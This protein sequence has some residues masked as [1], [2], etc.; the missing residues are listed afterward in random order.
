[1][2]LQPTTYNLQ[3][4]RGFTLVET[5]VAI[6][7]MMVAIV[8]PMSIASQALSTARYAKE[9]VTAF[10]L[11]QEGIELVRDIRGNNVISGAAVWNEGTLGLSSPGSENYCYSTNGC[12]IEAKDLAV[13]NCSGI[14]PV[15]NIDL[16]QLDPDFGIYTYSLIGTNPSQ[17]AR[18]IRI[19]KL[20]STE[21]SVSSTVSWASGAIGGTRLFTITD[22]LLNWQ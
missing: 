4:N 3:P 12:Y 5:L 11:A 17:F 20:S 8:A 18:T 14:C 21:I 1:M 9:Q 19:T 6:F 10:Y 16:N 7:V 13:Q 22:N 2:N 15:L